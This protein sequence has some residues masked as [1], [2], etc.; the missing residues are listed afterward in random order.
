MACKMAT[1]KLNTQVRKEQIA[2]AALEL[3]AAGGLMKLSVAAVARRV[4]LVPSALYRHFKGKDEVLD[5]ALGLIQDKLL[6]N[7]RQ[8]ERRQITP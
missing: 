8:C 3:V 2:Q 6:G 1:E 7:V 5:A 4:G